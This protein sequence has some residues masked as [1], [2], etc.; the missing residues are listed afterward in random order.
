MEITMKSTLAFVVA[1]LLTAAPTV[2]PSAKTGALSSTKRRIAISLDDEKSLARRSLQMWASDN[3][4]KPEK[5]FAADYVNHQEPAAVGG[6]KNIDLEGWKAV[7][8]DN[9][10]AFSD[11]QVRILMQIAE[12]DLVA[13]RWQ[14]SATQTG[15]YLGHPPTGNRATWTGVQIDRFENGKI[16]ESWVDW[17]KFRLFTELG[18]LK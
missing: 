2:S 1:C 17:D 8:E 7:V 9:H 13:T 4:D 3:T 11:F 12:G 18:F 16:V 6:V 5:V 14:F 10:R 15:P